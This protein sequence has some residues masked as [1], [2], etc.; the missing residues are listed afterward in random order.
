MNRRILCLVLAIVLCLSVMACGK[1]QPA[2][3][4]TEDQTAA[5]AP[6]T[7]ADA[8][9]EATSAEGEKT[10]D[11]AAEAQKQTEA[12]P[13]YQPGVDTTL[14]PDVEVSM[15]V[16]DGSE[17]PGIDDDAPSAQTP[18]ATAPAAQPEEEPSQIGD[19]FDLRSLTYEGYHALSGSDQKKV[20]AMF[21]TTD[22]FMVWYGAVEA[23]YKAQHPE[24]EI[25]EGGIVDAGNLGG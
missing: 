20:I 25:G 16:A 13:A 5:A 18:A 11:P 22:D 7:V 3:V 8:A 14:P 10:D 17:D 15:G 6:T 19:D 1:K 23:Q 4:A 9:Q 21:G 24:I 12:A 2:H